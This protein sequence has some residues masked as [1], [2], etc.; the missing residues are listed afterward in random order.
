MKRPGP[1]SPLATPRNRAR[2]EAL[3]LAGFVPIRRTRGGSWTHTNHPHTHFTTAGALLRLRQ[4]GQQLPMTG[5]MK[6]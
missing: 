6:P 4:E 1:I 5:D 2:W 3:E